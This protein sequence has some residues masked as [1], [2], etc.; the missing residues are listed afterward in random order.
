M[1]WRDRLRWLGL[2]LLGATSFAQSAAAEEPRASASVSTTPLTPQQTET[3]AKELFERGNRLRAAG[4]CQRAIGFFLAS[5]ELLA[6]VPNTLNAAYCHYELGQLD[7]ALLLYE[8]LLLD[9]DEL[10]DEGL[11]AK[12]ERRIAAIVP[13]VAR[14]SV[15]LNRSATLVVDGRSRG[16][17]PSARSLV[18]MPGKHEV[19]VVKTGFEQATRQVELKAGQTRTLAMQLR[20]LTQRGVLRIALRNH[21]GGSG[22]VWLDGARVG[23]LPFEAALAPGNHWLAVEVGDRG[24]GPQQVVIV[25]GQVIKEGPPREIAGDPVVRKEYLGERFKLDTELMRADEIKKRGK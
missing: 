23:D 17:L 8:A 11:R 13:K 20:P 21:P 3:R 10:L 14:L 6:A 25:D 12:L 1:A 22:A 7:E 16:E 9:H 4:D 18:L 15:Q 19:R 24:S 2:S 5:R